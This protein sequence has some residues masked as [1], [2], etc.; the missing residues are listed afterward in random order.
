MSLFDKLN[1]RPQERRLVVVVGI[2][3]FGL[4][5]FLMVFPMFGEFGRLQQRA[6]DARKTVDKFQTEITKKPAYQKE[7]T[8]LQG[9]VG[10]I[11]S[12]DAALRLYNDVQNQ[13]NLTGL[14]YV[15]ISPAARGSKSNAFFDETSVSVNIRTGEKELID[16]L[17]RLTD[18][19]LMIRAKS[20]DVGPDPTRMLLQGT[21][22]LVKS[23]Q[24]KPPAKAAASAAP[25]AAAPKA[26]AP[27]APAPVT[28][29]KSAPT[30]AKPPSAPP[31][32]G[33]TNRPK[34]IP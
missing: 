32:A 10:F 21:I 28:T 27:K 1:L 7:L 14:G 24:R 23:F 25:K 22:T 5:N 18:K 16:F 11:P 8:L 3:V 20:L 17:N 29:P 31:S 15:Q 2:V 34:K 30:T 26:A 12:E 13:A 4:I 33:I 19:E 6:L 9:D